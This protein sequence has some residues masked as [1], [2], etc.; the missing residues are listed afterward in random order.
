MRAQKSSAV[1]CSLVPY[2]LVE[3]Y[4]LFFSL[5]CARLGRFILQCCIPIGVSAC[6]WAPAVVLALTSAHYLGIVD[7][8]HSLII[9]QSPGKVLLRFRAK[10]RCRSLDLLHSTRVCGGHLPRSTRLGVYDCGPRVEEFC[11]GIRIGCW[12]RAAATA[13]S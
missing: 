1:C 2:L 11:G 12:Q 9:N 5:T 3:L 6:E 7:I 13:C 8:W 4:R 10:A